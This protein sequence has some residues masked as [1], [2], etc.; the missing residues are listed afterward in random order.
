MFFEG[1]NS[2]GLLFP[3]LV[4]I[5]NNVKIGAGAVVIGGIPSDSTAVGVPARVIKNNPVDFD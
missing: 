3:L 4:T 1:D 5:G 2:I